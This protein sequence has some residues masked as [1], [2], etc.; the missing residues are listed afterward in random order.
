M[1]KLLV[2]NSIAFAFQHKNKISTK[3]FFYLL[4]G[5]ALPPLIYD[6]EIHSHRT[7]YI[8]SYLD[9][10]NKFRLRYFTSYFKASPIDGLILA[11]ERFSSYHKTTL[12]NFYLETLEGLAYYGNL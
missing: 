8:Q 10:K 12:Q 6:R 11:T 5:G 1:L 4:N 9:N 3:A 7:F 2:G